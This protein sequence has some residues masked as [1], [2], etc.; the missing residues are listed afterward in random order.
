M[1]Y[2]KRVQAET[3]KRQTAYRASRD[4]LADFMADGGA[5]NA[6]A[7]LYQI[8]RSGVQRAWKRIREDL[9]PQA[10]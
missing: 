7:R 6:Y 1:S 9:G 10:I 2:C 4:R 5:I 3:T 8:D